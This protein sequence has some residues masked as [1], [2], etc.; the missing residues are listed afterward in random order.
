MKIKRIQHNL[1]TISI[2]MLK[3]RSNG[4]RSIVG[5]L[6]GCGNANITVVGFLLARGISLS[7]PSRTGHF[8]AGRFFWSIPSPSG[9]LFPRVICLD[10]LDVLY[11]SPW[12]R[13]VPLD[14]FGNT[15]V[16]NSQIALALQKT[17]YAL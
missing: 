7:P 14:H 11:A 1:I 4:Q 15:I 10:L 13:Q 8:E 6:T 5:R 9:D 3:I 17:N 2:P 16:G 12:R